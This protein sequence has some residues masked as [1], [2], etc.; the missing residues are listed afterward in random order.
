MRT[1]K[2][3]ADERTGREE[4]W[5][6]RQRRIM[7]MLW[8]SMVEPKL[9]LIRGPCSQLRVDYMCKISDTKIRAGER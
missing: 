4:R 7:R 9:Q 1:S 6:D 2:A 8:W 3:V 5:V